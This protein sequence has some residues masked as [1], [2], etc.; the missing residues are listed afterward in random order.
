MDVPKTLLVTNDFPPRVGGVQRT[1]HALA[2]QFPADRISVLAPRWEGWREHDASRPYEIYRFPPTF[3]WPTPALGLRT[4]SIV[5]ET[6][7]EVVLFGHTLPTALLGPGLHRRGIP[8]VVGAH[9][10]EYWEALA[11]GLAALI[12]RATHHASRVA[13][14]CSEFVARTLRTVVRRQTPVSVLYPGADVDRFRPDLPGD[15]VRQRLGLSD[16]PVVVCVSRLVPRKGQ[17]VLI[18]AMP[19]I[20]RRVPDAALLIVGGGE[21]RR[22]L[23]AMARDAPPHSVFFSSEVSEEELPLHY[24]AGDVFAMPCRNRF[25]G[26]EVEGWGN[27]FLEAAACGK[28]S[29]AGNSGGAAEAVVDGE[30]GLVVDGRHVGQVAEAVAGLLADEQRSRALGKAGR[31]RVERSFTWPVIAER[32]AVWLRQAARA[33]R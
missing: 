7:A 32:L 33:E 24:A 4:R 13:V 21:Y 18:R 26:L 27:V 15:I 29:V 8:Y 10:A 3:L 25:A 12:G 6:G 9:G 31:A 22:T 1:L 5:R 2:E 17:D 23:E 19:A 20:R 30:T 28:P 11:P 14:M 16:R